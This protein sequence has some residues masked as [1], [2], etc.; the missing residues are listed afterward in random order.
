MVLVGPKAVESISTFN[1]DKVIMSCKGIDMDKGITDTNEMFSQVKKSMLRSAGM[2]ILA[3][4]HTKFDKAAF[5]QICE[6]R[7]IDTIVTDIRPSDAWMAYFK[8]KG[9]ECLYG[10]EN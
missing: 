5:S 2:R 8:D 4:D 7:D 6:I 10:E 1:A 9:I 3:V